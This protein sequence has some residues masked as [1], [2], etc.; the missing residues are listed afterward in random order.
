LRVQ[1]A[2]E[3]G[4]KVAMVEYG[5]G[6]AG[7]AKMDGYEGG[8]ASTEGSRRR[9]SLLEAVSARRGGREW[10]RPVEMEQRSGGWCFL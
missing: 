7:E 8:S 1:R 5:S 2:E 6:V 3:L 9:R 10:R 4:E